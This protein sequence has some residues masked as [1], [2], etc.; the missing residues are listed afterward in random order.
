[1]R[2]SLSAFLAVA[3]ATT[4]FGSSALAMPKA[5]KKQTT[6]TKVTNL[7]E[8]ASRRTI[9]FARALGDKKVTL[10]AGEKSINIRTRLM[11]SVMV[12]NKAGAWKLAPIHYSSAKGSLLYRLT[13]GMKSV[14]LLNYGVGGLHR[15]TTPREVLIVPLELAK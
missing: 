6:K 11:D 8:K 1:M 2:I 4:S 14:K 5:S 10:R 15:R 9:G 12:K 3:I 7:K 13:P